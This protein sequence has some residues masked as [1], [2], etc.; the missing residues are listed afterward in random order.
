M[1]TNH[2]EG[3]SILPW[4]AQHIQVPMKLRRCDVELICYNWCRTSTNGQ[5]RPS[6]TTT[7]RTITKQ[8]S[9]PLPRLGKPFAAG[10]A[11]HCRSAI[12]AVHCSKMSKLGRLP[13]PSRSGLQP[14]WNRACGCDCLGC[15]NGNLPV[16][17]SNWCHHSSP[18]VWTDGRQSQADACTCKQVHCRKELGMQ[19]MPLSCLLALSIPELIHGSRSCGVENAHMAMLQGRWVSC[20]SGGCHVSQSRHG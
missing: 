16:I 1:S 12:V 9:C 7:S 8:L 5:A 13:L 3:V 15:K 17:Y 14:Q 10:T 20:S 19:Q 4:H 11:G 6:S 18:E 2:A